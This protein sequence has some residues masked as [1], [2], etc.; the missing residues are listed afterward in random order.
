MNKSI[1]SKLPTGIDKTVR[2]LTF[3]A[4]GFLFLFMT[5]RG[6]YRGG[7]LTPITLWSLPV[8]V[9]TLGWSVFSHRHFSPKTWTAI[10][11]FAFLVFLIGIKLYRGLDGIGAQGDRDDAL[12][13]SVIH[14]LQGRYPYDTPTFLDNPITTGPTSILVSLPFIALFNSPH[15]VSIMTLGFLAFYMAGYVKRKTG[16]AYLALFIATLTFIPFSNWAFWEGSEEVLYG[17]PFLYG[18]IVILASTKDTPHRDLIGGLLLGFAVMV[19]ISYVLPVA[20][21]WLVFALHRPIRR[22]LLV[23]LGTLVGAVLVSVPFLILNGNHFIHEFIRAV[24]L[25]SDSSYF[26]EAVLAVL[27]VGAPLYFLKLRHV[28]LSLQLNLCVAIC[29]VLGHGLQG[30]MSRPWHAQYWFIPVAIAAPFVTARISATSPSDRV[31]TGK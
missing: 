13:Q 18:A 25:G 14:L 24:W 16:V 1:L 8:L 30:L 22:S 7:F 17:F 29:V 6:N 4:T 20:V 26:V 11:I 3:F 9:A 5:L 28:D 15:V 23:G 10:L 27:L 21:V 31:E 19:R 2:F 12:Y